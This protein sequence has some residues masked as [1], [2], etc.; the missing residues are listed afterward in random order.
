[1]YR[2]TK[3]T[4]AVAALAAGLATASIAYAQDTGKPGSGGAVMNNGMMDNQKGNM[5]GG[6]M[7]QGGNPGTMNQGDMSGMMNM[8]GQMSRMMETCNNMMQMAMNNS[9][10]N[11]PDG[12]S[13][14]APAK[15]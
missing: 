15:P 8:M 6:M 9:G 5:N 14:A 7:G 1:M 13:S 11:P 10:K 12:K 4:A 2:I 3:T